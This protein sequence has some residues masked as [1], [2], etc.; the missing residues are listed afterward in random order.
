MKMYA[1]VLS[2]N[3]ARTI[4]R[5]KTSMTEHVKL[6]YKVIKRAAGWKCEESLNLDSEEHLLWCSG[7]DE[8]RKNLDLENE[9]D[10]S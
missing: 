10:L 5:R 2:L 1:E 6:N 8:F 7:Y 4:F 3:E 9:R